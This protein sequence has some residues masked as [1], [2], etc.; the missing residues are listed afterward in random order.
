MPRPACQDSD[1]TADRTAALGDI[2]LHPARHVISQ[3]RWAEPG[4]LAAALSPALLA[5]AAA[6]ST[7]RPRQLGLSPQLTFCRAVHCNANPALTL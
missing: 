5:G 7:P 6:F 1:A 4:G 3:N 2:V